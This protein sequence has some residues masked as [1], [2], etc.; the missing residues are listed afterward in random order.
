MPRVSLII[1]LDYI[2]SCRC[3]NSALIEH[4]ATDAVIECEGVIDR[5]CTQI[6]YLFIV[7]N[8]S[9]FGR[10]GCFDSNSPECSYPNCLLSGGHRRTED[11]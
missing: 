7:S 1:N 5:S 8:G 2:L 6:P 4:H 10:V 9:S 11:L 3:H